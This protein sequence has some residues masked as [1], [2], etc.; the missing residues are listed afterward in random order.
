M[1]KIDPIV[2]VLT[3]FRNTMGLTQQQLA[4]ESGLSLRTI[5]RLEAGETD[6]KLGQYRRIIEALGIS[7]M[8]VSVALFRHEF[9]TGKD[10]AAL[11]QS[12]P[13]DIRQVIVRFLVDLADK[14]KPQ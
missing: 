9:A 14:I 10:V 11:A 5:Q 6:M 8:D 7:D 3:K 13:L 4:D 2:P 1:A 12:L